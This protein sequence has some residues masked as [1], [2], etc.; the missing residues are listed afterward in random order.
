MIYDKETLDT[1]IS[2]RLL[3]DRIDFIVNGYQSLSVD[4]IK[5]RIDDLD[6]L[7]SAL[8]PYQQNECVRVKIEYIDSVME[9]M[10]LDME[11][12]HKSSKDTFVDAAMLQDSMI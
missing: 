2:Q 9:T 11:E 8:L 10:H 5:S 4:G 3:Q 7:R 6:S 12:K 1:L